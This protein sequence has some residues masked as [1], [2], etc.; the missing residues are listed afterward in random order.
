MGDTLDNILEGQIKSILESSENR[1]R[2]R[3]ELQMPLYHALI[4][5]I[6]KRTLIELDEQDFRGSHIGPE[7]VQY[8]ERVMMH[9]AISAIDLQEQ[10]I[11]ITEGIID[12]ISSA[13]GEHIPRFTGL[14][15]WEERS[16]AP[17]SYI[18]RRILIKAASG[19]LQELKEGM[20]KEIY[21]MQHQD[22][23]A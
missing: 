20:Q 7:S 9:E 15:N 16:R 10:A 17:D 23:I 3:T 12:Y 22:L 21:L 11:E 4:L 13:D 2:I 8:I 5:I 6:R 14:R 19:V 18:Y 1:A